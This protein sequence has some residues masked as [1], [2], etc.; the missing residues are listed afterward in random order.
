MTNFHLPLNFPR[1]F[2]KE[3]IPVNFFNFTGSYDLFSFSEVL[4][5][6]LL[7]FLK[8]FP[9]SPDFVAVFSNK[10]QRG[11]LE[12][13][14]I[15]SDITLDKTGEWKDVFFG[16][17]YELEDTVS[18]FH[19]WDTK[20]I[21]KIYPD[22]TKDNSRQLRFRKLNGIHYG[23]RGH[24]G[25]FQNSEIIES[26]EIKGPTLVRTDIPHCVTYYNPNRTRLAFS[27]R[28]KSDLKNWQEAV[29]FF[30]PFE[31]SEKSC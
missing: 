27:L 9:L 26:L 20:D 17:H 5:D 30:K 10:N 13:R 28:F 19:W 15:H 3:H 23:R 1:R 24:L 4:H 18:Q 2:L 16:I 22:A 6:E 31:L 25:K 8:D 14:M 21:E 12:N 11:L 7:S 29:D